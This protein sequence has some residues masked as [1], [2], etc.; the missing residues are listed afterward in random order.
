[1][2]EVDGPEPALAAITAL[3]LESYYPLH[4]VRADLL[5]RLGRLDESAAS[6]AA[7]LALTDNE[8]ERRFLE[9]ARASLTPPMTDSPP[10]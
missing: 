8:A 6:Y 1:L 2:A 5:R 9:R 10:P 4:A 7:A 3:P